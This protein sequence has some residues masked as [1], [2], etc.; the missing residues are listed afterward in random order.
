[1][2]NLVISDGPFSPES[3]LKWSAEVRADYPGW[4]KE[5]NRGPALLAEITEQ[6]AGHVCSRYRLTLCLVGEKLVGLLA[7]LEY[8]E[9]S[10]FDP[11]SFAVAPPVHG[12]RRHRIATYLRIGVCSSVGCPPCCKSFD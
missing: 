7:Y 6:A 8:E 10:Y 5:D 11:I 1:M 3:L 9:E 2:S 12:L 4:D